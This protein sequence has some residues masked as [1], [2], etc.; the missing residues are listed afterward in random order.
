MV[1]KWE[2]HAHMDLYIGHS[3][4]HATNIALILNPC[5][6]NVSPQFHVVFDDDFTTVPNLCSSQVQPFWEDLIWASTQ[7]HVYTKR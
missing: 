1:P 5:T 6:G 7:L 3:L 2:P 4:S